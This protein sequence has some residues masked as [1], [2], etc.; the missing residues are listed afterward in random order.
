MDEEVHIWEQPYI[1]DKLREPPESFETFTNYYLDATK[2]P[3]VKEL[4]AITGYKKTRIES[5]LFKY[6]YRH[7]RLEKQ[8][9]LQLEKSKAI[10][11]NNEVITPIL[12]QLNKAIVQSNTNIVKDSLERQNTLD[13]ME[14]LEPERLQIHKENND[15]T[16]SYKTLGEA[17]ITVNE[18]DDY[19]KRAGQ[20]NKVFDELIEQ[21][22]KVRF[23]ENK[24]KINQLKG[25]YEDEEY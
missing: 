12:A 1:T 24:D 8:K 25:E 10:K 2:V 16:K 21:V 9:Y 7:R 22:E 11:K 3:T 14:T 13:S 4:V 15:N 19:T 5:W 6:K 18:F 23:N 17:L 20:D